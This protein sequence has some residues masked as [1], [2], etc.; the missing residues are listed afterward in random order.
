[1][2]QPENQKRSKRWADIDPVVKK[3]I[4]PAAMT[5]T[6]SMALGRSDA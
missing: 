4:T 3:I 1:M 6:Q 5:I 2:N